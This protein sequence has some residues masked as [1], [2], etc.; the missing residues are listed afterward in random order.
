MPGYKIVLRILI[1]VIILGLLGFL[2]YFL[3]GG[4]NNRLSTYE[5]YQNIK[6]S[7]E[8]TVLEEH[9]TAGSN[10]VANVNT[11]QSS[12][13]DWLSCYLSQELLIYEMGDNLY[14]VDADANRAE[15]DGAL[16]S[17]REKISSTSQ[18]IET[19]LD[20]QNYFTSSSSDEGTALTEAERT[21]LVLLAGTAFERLKEQ[22]QVMYNLNNILFPFV[23]DN[24]LGGN[25]DASLKYGILYALLEQSNLLY[26][27]LEENTQI[28][29][30]ITENE[31]A[32]EVYINEKAS[33]FISVATNGSSAANF[34]DAM[35]N[36]SSE[37]KSEFFASTDKSTYAE[38]QSPAIQTNLENILT[39]LGWGGAWW[40][41]RKR[42]FQQVW[43]WLAFCA[44]SLFWVAVAKRIVIKMCKANIT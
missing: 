24:C 21:S 3:A 5:N 31:N 28:D 41:W 2:I 7:E 32:R 4:F 29:L 9:L 30:M 19:F 27:N 10:F 13:S 35:I 12:F 22:V 18:S 38:R 42:F 43:L 25:V 44:F 34:V 11:Y 26:N 15:V 40:A 14:F 23:V 33:D 8:N 16:N 6:N 39:F 36:L 1:V 37:T 17:Y 20:R